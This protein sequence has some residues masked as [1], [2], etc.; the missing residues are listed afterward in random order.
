MISIA[1]SLSPQRIMGLTPSVFAL[2][3]C[4]VAWA[5]G[6]EAP[7]RRRLA[8]A[9]TVLEA[10]L[11]LDMVFNAR[12]LLHD[13]LAGVAK[14]N[15]LYFRR[16]GPQHVAL[17][18][19]GSAVVAAMGLALWIFRGRPGASFAACSGLLSFCCWC[20]EV[21]SLHGVDSLLYH[22]VDGVM[23]VSLAWASCSLMT[24]VGILWDSFTRPF[25]KASS[26]TTR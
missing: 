3:S 20:V 7:R 17:A 11:L 24:G 21:I 14:V 26:H 22:R 18:L 4:A 10:G 8:A 6:R 1:G 15:N 16:A 5:R 25:F 12:W 9:L 19:L 2:G 13:L 23:I